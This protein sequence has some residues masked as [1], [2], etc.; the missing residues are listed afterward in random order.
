MAFLWHRHGL[1]RL[2]RSQDYW[3]DLSWT[4]FITEADCGAVNTRGILSQ[5]PFQC[6]PEGPPKVVTAGLALPQQ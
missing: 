2:N 6:L 5:C 3:C 1:W 4:V